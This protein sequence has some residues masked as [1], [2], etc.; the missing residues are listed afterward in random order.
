MEGRFELL[1]GLP[2]DV[3]GVVAKGKID[4]SAYEDELIPA[5]EKQ[6]REQGK[7]KLLYVLGDEFEGFT[8]GAA[9]DDARLGL[10]HLADFAKIAVVTD[11]DWI[12]LGVKMFAPLIP[13]DVHLYGVAELEAARAWVS[14]NAPDAEPVVKVAAD[15]TVP[16]ME[17]MG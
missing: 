7:V 13:C 8:A 12:K 11:A 9:W 6:I 1:T 10:M 15:R 4:R 5:V 16:S 14:E 2:K 17:D 3:V